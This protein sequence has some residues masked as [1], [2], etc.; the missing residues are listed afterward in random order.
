MASFLTITEQASLNNIRAAAPNYMQGYSDLTKRNHLLLAMMDQIGN[1]EYGASE[2]ARIWQVKV[3]NPT[4]SVFANTT[5]KTFLDSQVFEQMQVG[6]RGYEAS[7]LLK[8]LD[9]KKNRT[10]AGDHQ[11]VNLYDFKMETLG[12]AMVEHVQ[13]SIPKDGDA[14]ANSNGYQGFESCLL[15][16]NTNT[17]SDACTANDRV[18]VPNDTYGGISTQLG[19]LGGTWSSDIVAGNRMNI[20]Q[21]VDNDWP[22]GVGDSQ[23]DAL[24]PVLINYASSNWAG[25][26]TWAD[27]V[28]EC[29]REMSAILR[30]KNGMG[31]GSTD[32]VMLLAPN[33]YP[34][35][36]NYYSTRFRVNQPFTGGDQGFPVANSLYIDGTAVKQDYSIPADIG[37]AIAPEAIE[38]FNLALMNQPSSEA[39]MID[40][41]GP[42]WSES[43]AAFLMRVSTHGNLRMSPRGLGKF[44][45]TAHYNA[46]GA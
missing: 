11:L 19:N 28:E 21:N 38:F 16:E 18:V 45:T 32:I 24:S 15:P 41:F 7:D 40:T 30:N 43:H 17:G 14:A 33:L 26:T 3:R 22:Y 6:I 37:Y 35:A 42:T 4:V 31:M 10:S 46:Q 12:R 36:E 20:D 23:Y 25:G 34:Q 44:A 5:N 29:V 39:S 13:N 27:N 1:I 9:W 8:E 2:V